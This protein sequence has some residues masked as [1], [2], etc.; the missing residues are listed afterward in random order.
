MSYFATLTG[1]VLFCAFCA[2]PLVSLAQYR[3]ATHPDDSNS[4]GAISRGEWRGD[5]RTFR[6]LDRNRDGV[7]SG[8]EVPGARSGRRNNE[9]SY[10]RNN[11]DNR[12]YAGSSADRLDKNQSGV[13]E[14]HEWPYNRA[15]FHRLDRDRDSVLSPE[16]LENIGSATL[17]DLDRNRDGT[18]D[19][20]EWPGGFAKFER[21][22]NNR[23]GRVTA[24]EYFERG[25]EWRRRQRFDAWDKNRD[26]IIQSTEWKSDATLFHRLDADH[27]STVT[28]D[29][30]RSDKDRY[31]DP[32][33]RLR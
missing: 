11:R 19:S 28:W 9:R 6:E 20:G 25:G 24:D 22:D 12:D 33:A 5:A 15:M 7:L 4:D 29:E 3:P 27:D 8:N 13:V 14:G 31:L 2:V 16:E 26:G 21:L 1:K 10:E 30:F 23:D 18:V 32:P 17:S